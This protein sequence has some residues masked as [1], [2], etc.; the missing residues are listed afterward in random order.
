[1][2]MFTFQPGKVQPVWPVG[3]R[4]YFKYQFSSYQYTPEREEE[5]GRD[6]VA[7]LQDY[8]ISAHFWCS[9]SYYDF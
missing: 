3:A 4:Q 6:S 7:R 2:A 8:E 1:M 5:K 9:K